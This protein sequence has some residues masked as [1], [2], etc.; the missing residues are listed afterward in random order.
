MYSEFM[1]NSKLNPK[2]ILLYNV[3]WSTIFKHGNIVQKVLLKF[4]LTLYI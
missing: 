2:N 4:L 1:V 3:L